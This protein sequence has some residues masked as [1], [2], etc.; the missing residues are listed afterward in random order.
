MSEIPEFPIIENVEPPEVKL[1]APALFETQST[2]LVVAKNRR[3]NR[4]WE[5]LIERHA[6]NTRRC[7]EDLST[8]PTTRQ[9]GRV[10]PLKGKLYKGAWEYEVT[11]GDRVFYVPDEEL[12]KV[13]VY[14]AGKHP[15]PAPRP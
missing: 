2:W 4:D 10:F 7:Y 14:Y 5:A 13:V 3:V 12:L 6:E 8:A 15:S 1:T 11:K 9:P